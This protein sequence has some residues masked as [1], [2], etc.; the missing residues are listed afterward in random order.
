M[1]EKHAHLDPETMKNN[2]ITDIFQWANNRHE[3]DMTLLFIKRK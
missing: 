1:V 3:D 2:I